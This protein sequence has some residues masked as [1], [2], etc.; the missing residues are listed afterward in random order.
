M[1]DCEFVFPRSKSKKQLTTKDT[2][3]TQVNL[4]CGDLRIW[5]SGGRD[6]VVQR[7]GD[8]VIQR[9]AALVIERGDWQMRFRLLI[10][11][12][13]CS[14]VSFV[15]KDLCV[16]GSRSVSNFGQRKRPP[17]AALIFRMNSRMNGEKDSTSSCGHR[18]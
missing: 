7:S 5:W 17:E 15:V 10:S 3:A 11:F 12:P 6:R 13:L 14:F 2:K 16:C 8:L 9:S 1:D 18:R 4:E